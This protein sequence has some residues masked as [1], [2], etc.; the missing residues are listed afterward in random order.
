MTIGV[1]L[2]AGRSSRFLSPIP[3]QLYPINDKPIINY[4]I[5]ILSKSLDDVIIITNSSY[6]DLIQTDKTILINDIDDRIQ[7]IKVALDYLEMVNPS[8]ILI[9]DAA[10]PFI[11]LEMIHKLLESQKTNLHSQYYLPILNG[12][13]HNS[14]GD[15]EIPNRSEFIQLCSPQITQFDLFKSLFREKIL[16]GEECEI[17]PLVSKM[18]KD[19]NLIEG[20]Y[21]Q[22]RKI[23]TIEDI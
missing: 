9:H 4:S 18:K 14:N 7:S 16:P 19:F 2:A 21:S 22:L 13:A 8:N 5:D 10:R 1:I 3:K 20:S 6:Y 23:T 12:L 17:L 11:T 15:W